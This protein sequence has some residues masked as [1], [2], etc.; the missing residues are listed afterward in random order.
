MAEPTKKSLQKLIDRFFEYLE[1]GR[2]VSPETLR[3]YKADM[4]DFAG[5]CEAQKRFIP[6]M[7]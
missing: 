2:G 4:T 1:L 3:A 6:E 7:H 5:F